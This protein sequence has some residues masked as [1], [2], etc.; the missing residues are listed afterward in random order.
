[1]ASAAYA[2]DS[3]SSSSGGG[4]SSRKAAASRSGFDPASGATAGTTA[5]MGSVGR[6][7]AY[8]R[9]ATAFSA[10]LRPLPHLHG[11]PGQYAGRIHEA[12]RARDARPVG[13]MHTGNYA[14]SYDQQKHH[15]QHHYIQQSSLGAG[16]QQPPSRA[17]RRAQPC[18]QVEPLLA[19][20]EDS[21]DDY[22]TD[23]EGYSTKVIVNP[24]GSARLVKQHPHS[25]VL[26]RPSS[27][28]SLLGAADKGNL[29]I[30]ENGASASRERRV[31]VV[32]RCR[33]A[34]EDEVSRPMYRQI[35]DIQQQP[36]P[37]SGQP[38]RL[39]DGKSL[40]YI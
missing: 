14:Q 10:E 15:R 33:P 3:S 29:G 18:E 19:L 25:G 35:V 5:A 22:L 21:N 36:P 20:A 38:R 31:K 9:H 34:F 37:V 12:G 26:P 16:L 17:L 8:D 7:Y 2:A 13:T 27:T 23:D 39:G 28:A 6:A 30:H 32:V 40:H 4:S 1:M 24:A 11:T